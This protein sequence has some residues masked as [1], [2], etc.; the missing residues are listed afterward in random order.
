MRD[1]LR[2]RERERDNKLER[3]Q[4]RKRIHIHLHS[5]LVNVTRFVLAE[6]PS[7]G[8]FDT[9]IDGRRRST[10]NLRVRIV[11]DHVLRVSTCVCVLLKIFLK[12]LCGKLT[13]AFRPLSPFFTWSFVCV[14]RLILYFAK[15]LCGK[16]TRPLKSHVGSY[17]LSTR[18]EFCVSCGRSTRVHVPYVWLP[19]YENY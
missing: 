3:E 12:S 11:P 9:Q 13:W 16:I 7:V 17:F 10:K 19:K 8:I 5:D 2:E 15:S 14:L 18:S 6:D 1:N 4:E